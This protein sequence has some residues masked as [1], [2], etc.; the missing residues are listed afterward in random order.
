[1]WIQ[2]NVHLQEGY[3]AGPDPIPSGPN[4]GYFYVKNVS[5]R[6]VSASTIRQGFDSTW[7]T[8]NPTP[9]TQLN[10]CRSYPGNG[11]L[12]QYLNWWNYNNR[13][14]R[15]HT[16]AA[17]VAALYRHELDHH[18]QGEA[19]AATYDPRAAVEEI[20]ASDLA[21]I[22]HRVRSVVA[23]VNADLDS[24]IEPQPQ[25]RNSWWTAFFYSQSWHSHI[26]PL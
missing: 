19:A 4:K 6:F 21:T 25:A 24:A 15:V 13:C 18:E 1:M 14:E 10:T 7:V 16:S 11:G 2:P 22:H 5:F 3:I 23:T 8:Q 26:W 9:A 12:G 20:V 17:I